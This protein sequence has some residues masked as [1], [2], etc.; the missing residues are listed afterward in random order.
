MRVR[1][2]AALLFF[3]GAGA[4]VLEVVWFRRLAQ[5]AGATSV[6]L[7]AV[8]A[9]IIGGM[10]LGAFLGGGHAER[11]RAPLRLYACLEL[12]IALFALA[13]PWILDAS[14]AAFVALTR[15]LP[16]AP[17]LLALGRFAL[18]ALMLAPAAI[19][20][21]ATLPAMAAAVA[22]D[23]RSA[24]S[25]IGLL[26]AFNTL[27]AVA[28]TI[29]AGFVLV[30]AFGLANTMRIAAAFSGLAAL[31]ALVLRPAPV[32]P[33]TPENT[34]GHFTKQDRARA[35]RLLA[36][37]GFLGM[38]AEG[39]FVRGLVLVFGST[40]Y[41]FTIM[42]AVFLFGLAS[43]G[44]IGSRLTGPRSPHR[45]GTVVAWTAALF[46]VGAMSLYALPRLYLMGYAAWGD[47]FAAD[48]TLRVA[49][50]AIVLLPGALGLGIAFPLAVDVVAE[51]ARARGTGRL[52]AANSAAS[53]LGST[54]SVFALVPWLGPTRAI[55]GAG[56]VAA[57]VAW[58]ET[59]SRWS[60]VPLAI[61]VAAFT[62]PPERARERMY[63]GIYLQPQSYLKD[64]A[65]NEVAWN[66][67]RDISF[68][69]HGREATIS[70]EHWYGAASIYV[71]GKTVA[72]GQTMIEVQ[73]LAAL[74]HVPM[75]LHPN[76]ERVLI[77]GLGMGTTYRAI[78]A[79]DP[80]SITVVEL[81]E[82]IGEAA[83]TLGV[84]PK[85]VVIDDGRAFLR[86]TREKYDVISSDTIHPWVRGGGDLYTLEYFQACRDRL[87]DGGLI[88]HWL[89][90]Y[91]MSLDDV[92]AVVRTFNAVFATSAYFSGTNLSLIGT[93][94][95]R[96]LK[97]YPPRS[98]NARAALVEFGA[99]DMRDL[100]V[101]GP[102]RAAM[103]AGEGDV[104]T[105]DRLRLEYSTP[106]HIRSPEKNAILKWV[107]DQWQDPRPPYGA[108]MRAIHASAANDHAAYQKAFVEAE[109]QSP[110]NA[111]VRRYRG[112]KYMQY[113][114][115]LI[116]EGDPDQA[117]R[118]LAFAER[119][120]PRDTRLWGV[121]AELEESRGGYERAA[122]L[123]AALLKKTPKSDYLRR[124]LERVR[125]AA[126]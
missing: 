103:A 43:G 126:R 22:R 55:A 104:L 31:C 97:S 76:P 48:T 92:R 71:N 105:E 108:L 80:R 16:E 73:H 25:S 50:S 94:G 61:V 36:A 17:L 113:A 70:I 79:H 26:Y 51:H 39:A 69:R 81:E 107:V 118:Y 99:V 96:E 20:M 23:N 10:A 19:C 60:L 52:Y 87:A 72:S 121:R 66:S 38:A 120:L 5:V 95:K 57:L 125:A 18:A 58:R 98:S 89:P 93:V 49:L 62:P 47:S 90:L 122:E 102:E 115:Q 32:A 8:L 9:A 63:G 65:I 13:S 124:R 111:F 35:I 3:S 91:Q 74:G 100:L 83:A 54:L 40:T 106:R 4:L 68:V 88:C 85:H 6:A 42:L 123:L 112:E 59:R 34:P 11:S 117:E 14:G 33:P 2:L 110:Q 82:A 101:F 29:A 44:A 86:A 24:G 64:G 37:S 41:A 77:V 78:A 28:G 109:A 114:R 84:R 75:V 7:A 53:V 12:F 30:P 27:G 15:A 67:G 46:A 116:A 21:G 119:Y 56:L 1:I 45:L